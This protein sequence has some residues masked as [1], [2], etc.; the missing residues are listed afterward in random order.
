MSEQEPTPPQER[1]AGAWER[2]R[3]ALRSPGRGQV[4]VAVLLALLG[5]AMMTQLRS[6][7]G[8]DSY[9]GLRSAELVQVLNGLTVENR[10]A[11]AEI[12]ELESA[13]DELLDS[14][15]QRDAAVRQAREES[16]ALSILAGTQPAQGP[17]IKIR[18][19]DPD[20]DFTLNRIL[21]GVEEL[22]DA[23]AE[24]IE[25]ND[26]VRVTA[27]TWFEND[28]EGGLLIDG[29]RLLSPYLIEVI[30]DPDSMARSMSFPGG[31]IDDVTEQGSEVSVTKHEVIR[32][33]SVVPLANPEY[34]EPESGQ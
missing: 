29:Q 1:P 25:I 33:R 26:R 4:A 24:V 21:D 30:G 18:V 6:A 19:I 5:F 17:G 12:N 9:A 22:R 16:V 28:P 31:F 14:T 10:R 8:E 2:I 20:G 27:Q 3:S 23:G 15:Q 7:S 34:A 32:V 13:R 11:T